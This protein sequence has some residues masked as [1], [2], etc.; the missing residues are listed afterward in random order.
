MGPWAC[1][2]SLAARPR[3]I[4]GGCLRRPRLR[5]ADPHIGDVKPSLAGIAREHFAV[6]HELRQ[7]ALGSRHALALGVEDVFA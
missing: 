2:L 3:K 5:L 7:G 1:A 6:L 4:R